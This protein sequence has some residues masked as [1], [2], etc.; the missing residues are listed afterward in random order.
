MPNNP[1]IFGKPNNPPIFGFQ[2][3]PLIFGKPNHP[4]I[5]EKP[6]M[7]IFGKP[8]FLFKEVPS[9]ERDFTWANSKQALHTNNFLP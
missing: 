3:N 1:P 6:N 8:T 9:F 2:N 5:C 7:A 4:Q